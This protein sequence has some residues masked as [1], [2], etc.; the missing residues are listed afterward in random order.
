MDKQSALLNTDVTILVIDDDAMVRSIVCDYLRSFGFNSLLEASNG[1]QALK[2]IRDKNVRI[3]LIL[4]DWEMPAID[5]LTVLKA[6]RK[7][8]FRNNVA[9]I[10]ITSQTPNEV[11]KINWARRMKVTSYIVKP[12]TSDVLKEKVFAALG[13]AIPKSEAG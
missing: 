4:S 2:L 12:F 6:T 1:E 11:Q 10:M 8:D 7:I 3:N 13:V 9:F 5:G